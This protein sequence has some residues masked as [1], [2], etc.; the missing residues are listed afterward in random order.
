V[1]EFGVVYSI[2]KSWRSVRSMSSS[3]LMSSGDGNAAVE[4]RPD[5]RRSPRKPVLVVGFVLDTHFRVKWKGHADSSVHSK[6]W[7]CSHCDEYQILRALSAASSVSERLS[8]TLN[9]SVSPVTRAQMTAVD[10]IL[11]G[12]F[13]SGFR[14][15]RQVSTYGMLRRKLR[16][17]L[18]MT[19]SP[20][21]EHSAGAS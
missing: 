11:L 4:R 19:F 10:G 18:C 1:F 21:F 6:V 14:S 5:L 9:I 12:A 3:A 2:A 16:S 20:P 17:R 15:F 8:P 7:V 13:K